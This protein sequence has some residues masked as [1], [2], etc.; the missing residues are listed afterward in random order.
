MA[1]YDL[2]ASSELN[3]RMLHFMK[4]ARRESRQAAA[5]I[6]AINSDA[7]LLDFDATV[8]LARQACEAVRECFSSPAPEASTPAAAS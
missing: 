8:S 1:A 7:T 3:R 4:H 5:L 2:A 6:W